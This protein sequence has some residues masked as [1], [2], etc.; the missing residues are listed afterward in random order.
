M[1]SLLLANFS[2]GVSDGDEDESPELLGRVCLSRVLINS[3]DSPL[4]LRDLPRGLCSSLA[5]Y[6]GLED[7]SRTVSPF[8]LMLEVLKGESV[9]RLW[10]LDCVLYSGRYPMYA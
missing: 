8:S 7:L 3:F 4:R 9:R 5:V 1:L 6:C 10:H 2:L